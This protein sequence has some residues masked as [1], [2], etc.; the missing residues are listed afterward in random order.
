MMGNVVCTRDENSKFTWN[1]SQKIKKKHLRDLE[2]E[3]RIIRVQVLKRLNMDW[4][5]LSHDGNQ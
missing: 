1:S 4:T 3:G 2:V 5:Y